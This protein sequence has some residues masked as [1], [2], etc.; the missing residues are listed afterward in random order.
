MELKN[1]KED[2]ISL[3][4]ETSWEVCNKVGGIYTVLSSAS[5]QLLSQFGDRLIFIGPD[6]RGK[7]DG[8]NPDFMERKTLN[9]RSLSKLE[10]PYGITVSAGRWD[11]HGKPQVLL[12]GYDGVFEHLNDFF[13]RMWQDFGVD[14]LH[15]YGDYRESCAFSIASAIVISEVVKLLKVAPEKVVTHWH[16]WTTGMGLLETQNIMP[17]AATVFTTHATSIGRSICSNGKPLY[18]Y[19]HNYNGDQ[20][21]RELNMEAK[22]SLEKTAAKRAD[23][24]TTVSDVTAVECEQLLRVRPA[25]VTPN[26]F[27]ISSVPKGKKYNAARLMAR[28][29]ILDVASRISGVDFGED[30]FIVATSG[31]NEFRNKGLDLF[32]DSMQQ[33]A[34]TQ[35]NSGRK[36]LALILVP[37]WTA[38][39]VSPDEEL[40]FSTHHLH[41]EAEDPIWLRLKSFASRNNDGQTA[42]IYVPCYLDGNDGMINLSYYDLLPGMDATVFASYYEPWGYTPLESAAFGIPTVTTDKAGFGQWILSDFDNGFGMSGVFVIK[43]TDTNYDEARNDIVSAVYS[44]YEMSDSHVSQIRHAASETARHADWSLFIKYYDRAFSIALR[45]RLKRLEYSK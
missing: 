15:E 20:M 35:K 16:E 34:E 8:A 44:L 24:F 37:A 32:L 23:C 42:I 36:V 13:A 43:R 2:E 9:K 40:S 6:R 26:G 25:I 31:R 30:T 18:E 5:A 14:S 21:A 41:N 22:H 27:E 38:A 19:F 39:P 4:F 29:R 17:E 10:L 45:S 7:H 11:V 1:K 12:V 28:K 33:F 3:L